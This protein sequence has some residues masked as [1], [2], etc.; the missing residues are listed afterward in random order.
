MQ[1]DKGLL[2]YLIIGFVITTIIGTLSHEFGH[3]I[4]AKSLGYNSKI[5]Y[6]HTYWFNPNNN[7][8][9]N[10]YHEYLI[11]LGGSL[12]TIFIGMIGLLFVFIFRKSFITTNLLSFKQWLIIFISL[13]WLRQPANF[14]V[15]MGKYIFYG[16]LS[17]R[18]DE[19]YISE[20][21]SL[22]IWAI[23]AITA[24][25]GFVVLIVII[26]MFIPK[27]QRLT[28]TLS[29]LIGGLIGYFCWLHFIGPIL[30]P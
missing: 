14:I 26:F 18:L 22:S 25:I 28:F 19:A 20:Y 12:Q 2:I 27:F 13:F 10:S 3:F 16:N 8:A 6:G 29:G 4:V 30:M 1:L 17:T 11:T 23:P 5:N 21:L 15:W 24:L 9:N 7:K